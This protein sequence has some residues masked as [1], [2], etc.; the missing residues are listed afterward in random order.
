MAE[1]R[2]SFAGAM[3][4][5][6]MSRTPPL[7]KYWDEVEVHTKLSQVST[8]GI[9]VRPDPRPVEKTR[10]LKGSV[11]VSIGVICRETL[12]AD[13]ALILLAGGVLH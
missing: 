5:A 3:P 2:P 6:Y 8:H 12:E 4:A 10:C 7:A 9:D 11:V 1:T 13:M